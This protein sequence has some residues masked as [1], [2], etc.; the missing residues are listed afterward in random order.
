MS[1]GPARTMREID[2]I[3]GRIDAELDE[4]GEALPP[5][6]TLRRKATMAA[7]GAVTTLFTLWFVVHRI[8]IRLQDRRVR[9][10]IREAIEEANEAPG[11][12]E[13]S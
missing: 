9:R 4:L 7:V 8:R 1:E 3:R 12:D 11:G 5:A 10:I 13:Q 6:E 2:E